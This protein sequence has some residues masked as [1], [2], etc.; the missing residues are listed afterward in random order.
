MPRRYETAIQTAAVQN[1]ANVRV[2]PMICLGEASRTSIRASP[3]TTKTSPMSSPAQN[4][5]LSTGG[6][7]IS[8]NL[9]ASPGACAYQ[10]QEMKLLTFSIAAGGILGYVVLMIKIAG[11]RDPR[12]VEVVLRRGLRI[13]IPVA[14]VD[15]ALLVLG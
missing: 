13:L 12:D 11:L 8:A 10:P 4:P 15:T 14:L 5:V 7:D 9:N 2:V 6:E 1:T 3:G